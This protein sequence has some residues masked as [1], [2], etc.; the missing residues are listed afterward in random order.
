MQCQPIIRARAERPEAV[1]DWSAVL[2]RY[3]S[4]VR[5]R[6]VARRAPFI[7]VASGQDLRITPDSSQRGRMLTRSDFER[8]SPLLGRGGRDD[9]NEASRNSSYVEAILADFQA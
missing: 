3:R 5:L 1:P 6:T 2:S 7:V 4:P 8:A 9:V